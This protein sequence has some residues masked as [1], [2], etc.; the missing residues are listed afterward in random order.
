MIFIQSFWISSFDSFGA[1]RS[2]L[3]LIP[4]QI[5]LCLL[6]TSIIC[7]EFDDNIE[8]VIGRRTSEKF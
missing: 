2:E 1:R 4:M 8:Q 5:T 7:N 3:L 6:E